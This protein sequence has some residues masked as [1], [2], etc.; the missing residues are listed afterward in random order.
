MNLYK[1]LTE[2]ES[3]NSNKSLVTLIS[4]ILEYLKK[5]AIE[6]ILSR[7]KDIR[8]KIKLIIIKKVIKLD[9]Y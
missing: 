7:Q 3:V 4:I 8:R 1:N 5:D 6:L 2:I 9:G